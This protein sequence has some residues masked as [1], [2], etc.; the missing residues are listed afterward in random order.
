MNKTQLKRYAK[1]LAKVGV[2]VKKGQWV[3]VQADLDQPEFVEMVVEELYRAGAGR[4]IVEWSHQPLAK[5]NYKY[6]NEKMLS[7]LQK[8]E[9]EKLEWTANE[10]PAMLY[11]ESSDPDGLK[12]IDQEKFTAVRTARTKVTKPY[13]DRME[14]KY[15]WCI[16]AVPGK[17]WAKKVFPELMVN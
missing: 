3:I 10:L 9:T 6:A 7:E 17:A 1:L 16:A 15:Q 13:R 14:C 4:V 8:W 11:L 12:G 5:I 2:N